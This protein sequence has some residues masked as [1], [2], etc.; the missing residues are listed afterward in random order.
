MLEVEKKA[1]NI[2]LLTLVSDLMV[3]STLKNTQKYFCG[4][5]GMS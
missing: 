5:H 4:M 1:I 2:E 3:K